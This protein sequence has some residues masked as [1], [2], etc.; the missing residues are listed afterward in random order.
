MKESLASFTKTYIT[1]AMWCDMVECPLMS[2][3]L[4]D[5]KVQ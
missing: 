1:A 2:R 3:K 5:L 4:V